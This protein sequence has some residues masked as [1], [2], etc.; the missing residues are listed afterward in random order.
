[1]VLSQ[2][3]VLSQFSKKIR[4]KVKK[5]ERKGEKEVIREK[6]GSPWERNKKERKKTPLQPRRKKEINKERNNPLKEKRELP[7]KEPKESPKE[8]KEQK[9]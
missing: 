8:A 6:R 9:K 3:Y 5:R 1:M 7:E 2:S 4:L